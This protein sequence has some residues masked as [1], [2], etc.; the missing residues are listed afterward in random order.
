MRSRTVAS[1]APRAESVVTNASGIDLKSPI[2]RS[3]A[4]GFKLPARAWL[5]DIATNAAANVALT[6]TL[7]RIATP[8]ICFDRDLF[9]ITALNFKQRQPFRPLSQARS[10]NVVNRRHSL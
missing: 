7:I 5:T 10:N 8:T 2:R 4:D 1:T 9:V 6:I 3:D